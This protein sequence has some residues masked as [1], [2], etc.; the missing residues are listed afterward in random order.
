MPKGAQEGA[1]QELLQ[2]TERMMDVF[3]TGSVLER[4][5]GSVYFTTV[6]F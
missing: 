2:R 5:N 1:L 3:Q 4:I 6:N